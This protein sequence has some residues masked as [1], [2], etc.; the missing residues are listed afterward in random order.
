MRH[1]LLILLTC[2]FA[3]N[4][5]SSQA[6]QK[7]KFRVASFK[8]DPLDLSA[9]NEEFKKMD[10]NGSLY[11]IIKVKSDV[12]DDNLQSFRFNFGMMN[13]FVELH[14]DLDELWIYVQKNAKTVTISREGYTTISKYDLQTT[15]AA[16]ATYLMQLSVQTPRVQH[17]ILQFKVSPADESA[18]VKVKRED[19]SD[20]FELWGTVDASG[21][22]DRR[23]ETGVYLYEIAA[24]NYE[25]SEGRIILADAETNYVE[26][27]TL[28]PNFGWLEIEDVDN[29]AGAEFYV[30]NRKIGT[31]PYTE[32]KKWPVREGYRLMISAGELYK[33]YN[34]TFD[35]RKGEVTR[36]QPHLTSDFAKTTITVEGD[37][38][39]DIYVNG[40][41]RGTGRWN[42]PLKA[43]AYTVESRRE[44][45]RST[46]TQIVVKTGQEESFSIAAP[47]PIT[48]SIYVSSQPS[49]ARV[50]LD[51]V[52]RG[53]SPIEL[54]NV[55][56]GSHDVK[57]VLKNYN[58]E[59]QKVTVKEGETEEARFTLSNFVKSEVQPK[60]SSSTKE[61]SPSN[62]L[63]KPT[64][65]YAQLGMSVGSLIAPV[66]T[67]GA[68]I[69]NVNVE[70]SFL[71]YDAFLYDD[72]INEE[73]FIYWYNTTGSGYHP[74]QTVFRP[75]WAAGGKV[76]YGLNFGNRLRLTPQVGGMLISVF[77]SNYDNSGY[78]ITANIGARLD[79][80][81]F[82]FLGLYVAP[83]FIFPVSKSSVYQKISDSSDTV[84]GW[85]NGLCLRAGLTVFF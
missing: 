14:D 26:E 77:D 6:Q 9:R 56:V 25:T 69:K 33:T 51:D 85:S 49:G 66:A 21:A 59:H 36:L 17:R 50:F 11:A 63:F 29:I 35:I 18:I 60:T 68:Y 54:K 38:K 58:E 46:T 7:L 3:L 74:Y 70:A 13:S 41:R 52:D 62:Q 57:L 2:L 10:S 76:G 22:I 34:A 28:K 24:E 4:V 65:I 16:G 82:P 8:Q 23:L 83:E 45:H 81:V 75:T 72:Y 31:I 55:L 12:E 39:A 64:N 61:K 5:M 19:S 1:R 47:T 37:E 30:D 15:I 73:Q 43:G 48:G 78:A 79:Y 53:Q 84:K 40:T 44:N 67:L 32:K 27:V 42:G 20:D 71:Y 80:A